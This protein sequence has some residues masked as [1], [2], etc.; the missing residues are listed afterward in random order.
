L[1]AA[2]GESVAALWCANSSEEQLLGQ[3]LQEQ[4]HEQLPGVTS[5]EGLF[6]MGEDVRSCMGIQLCYVHQVGVQAWYKARA[7][8]HSAHRAT[9]YVD[10]VQTHI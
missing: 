3:Q 4:L 10:T 1:H 2:C 9:L 8:V 5:A 7:S 6:M